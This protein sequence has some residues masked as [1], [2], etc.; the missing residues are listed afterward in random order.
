MHTILPPKTNNA[1]VINPSQEGHVK[2][3][4]LLEIGA[5][6]PEEYAACFKRPGEVR[7]WAYREFRDALLATGRKKSIM[8]GVTTDIRLIFTVIDAVV[9][10]FNVQAAMDASGSPSDYF[11]EF[12]RQYMRNAGV[13]LT[14][15]NTLMSEIW[16]DRV[17]PARE[18]LGGL[19]S[20]V[21][22]P[23]IGASIV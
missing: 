19:M 21:V 3:P 9:E 15:N 18:E 10:G 20:T 17:A 11:E 22:F 2:G 23:A 4:I 16:Q 8:A 12:A 6:L 1:T 5:F 14:A 13:L 7:A